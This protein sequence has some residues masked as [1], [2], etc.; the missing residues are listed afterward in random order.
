M[1]AELR[2]TT[3]ALKGRRVAVDQNAL[4]IGRDVS[5]SVVIPREDQ[6][7]VSRVHAI[8]SLESGR[9]IL[10]DQKSSNGT[11]LNGK[12]ITR[13]HLSAGD[14]IQFG[15][16]GPIAIFEW[17][18]GEKTG[19]P[20]A[21]TKVHVDAPEGR[22]RRPWILAAALVLI[23]FSGAA[24]GGWAYYRARPE[25]TF[26]R[27]AGEYR[28]RVVLIEMGLRFGDRYRGVGQGT[29]FFVGNDGFIITNKHVATGEV[30]DF[31]LACLMASLKRHN[32]PFQRVLTA[33][34]GGTHFRQA[35]DSYQGDH[36][37]GYSTDQNTLALAAV[38][39]DGGVDR[40]RT[41]KDDDGEFKIAWHQHAMDNNDLAVLRAM[42][43]EPLNGI[44]LSPREPGPDEP[45]MVFGFPRGEVPQ[46]TT[47]AEPI[48]HVGQ[49]LRTQDTIQIDASVTHGNSG[50]PLIDMHGD[51]LGITTRGTD[52]SLSMAIKVEY[53]R[54]LLDRA[55]LT[56]A[57]PGT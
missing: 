40:E 43:T 53:A 30:Y 48:R 42:T 31:E 49:V 46:E 56:A 50:G 33:W 2:F 4:R 9:Y 12:P 45:V 41:C 28:D 22:S 36:G 17:A 54:K 10:E 6:E 34:K 26:K 38:G 35:S 3:G 27:L 11:L 19:R 15:R 47:T 18:D 57:R 1:S 13:A 25:Q 39:P 55:R 37:L 23:V 14:Q 8:I 16:S 21:Q 20:P 29:G 44:P 7:Y 52:P 24:G 32:I 5:N 51:V